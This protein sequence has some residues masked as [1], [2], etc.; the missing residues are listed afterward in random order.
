MLHYLT[1]TEVH[2]KLK[3]VRY[4]VESRTRKKKNGKNDHFIAQN[5]ESRWT[6]TF[7]FVILTT[8]DL[9]LYQFG[10]DRNYSYK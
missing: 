2:D 4:F 9:N 5:L 3:C 10:I 1:D 8:N 7:K 6:W